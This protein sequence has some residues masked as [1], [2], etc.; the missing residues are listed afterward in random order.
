MTRA[1]GNMDAAPAPTGTAGLRIVCDR[2][3]DSPLA[4]TRISTAFWQGEG[5]VVIR[6]IPAMVCPNCG[7]EYVDDATVVALDRMRGSGF[8]GC[9]AADPLPVPVFEFAGSVRCAGP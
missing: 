4:G 9:V 3:E 7:E 6:N 8:A 1:F 5:L 2:C